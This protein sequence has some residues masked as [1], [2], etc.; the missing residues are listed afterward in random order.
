MLKP[1]SL[2][3][4]N[5]FHEKIFFTAKIPFTICT[6]ILYTC[7]MLM[8]RIKPV[9]ISLWRLIFSMAVCIL[10][11]T[12]CTER[13]SVE[14]PKN[15]TF[16]FVPGAADPFYYTM[17]EGVQDGA[18]ERG[19]TLVE[20]P[21]P[22]VWD[23]GEQVGILN[24]YARAY[25]LDC[26]IIAPASTVKLVEPLKKIHK[27]GTKV[28]TVDTYIG[29]GNYLRSSEWSFP[30][31]YIGSDN[32]YGGR[33]VADLLSRMTNQKGEIYISTT[34]S[35]VSSVENRV[36]G[37]YDGISGYPS[38]RIV[39]IDYNFNVRTQAFQQTLS[40]LQT[41]PNMTAIFG[42]NVISSKGIY[43]AVTSSG[44]SGVYRIFFWDTIPEF[45][46]AVRDGEAD[47]VVA[48]KP[49][50]MGYTAVELGYEYFT[51]G[52]TAPKKVSTDLVLFTR[53]NINDPELDKYIY[54]EE[55]P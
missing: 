18:E 35:D 40:A 37:F 5:G 43:D 44:M 6:G 17:A 51:E 32:T 39:S 23:A 12:G 53:E 47:A 36:S 10:I 11:F 45:V 14:E 3:R 38:L 8:R 42:T 41:Y 1:S 24:H 13:T 55:A 20:A 48:Q 52:K 27:A 16:L 25:T 19:I 30:L 54:R 2:S 46:Q 50:E 29:D 4:E 34:H 31:S 7:L 33:R 15:L 26:V 49:Y 9:V 22:E 28:I 21:Y